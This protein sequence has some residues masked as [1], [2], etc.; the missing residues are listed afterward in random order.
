MRQN[1]NNVNEKK[2]PS[3]SHRKCFRGCNCTC[4]TFFL[5]LHI[6]IFIPLC[7]DGQGFLITLNFSPPRI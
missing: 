7:C 4:F 2:S 5:F 1:E 6:N 3:Q